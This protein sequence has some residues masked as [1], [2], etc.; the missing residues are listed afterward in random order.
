MTM[1]DLSQT[2]VPKSDQL[3]ADD[4]IA[5]PKTITITR[6]SAAA[7][8]ADQPV[9]ISYEGDDGKPYKP[10]K[11]M[12][13]VLVHLWGRDGAA[14][15]G[16]RMT[17]YRD[18]AVRFGG[19]EVGGIRISHMSHIDG[20]KT[21]ALTATRGSRK[22]YSVQPLEAAPDKHARM[23]EAFKGYGVEAAQILAKLGRA[24]LADITDADLATLRGYLGD[25]KQKTTTAANLF[26]QT[27]SPS[28][29]E[30][31]GADVRAADGAQEAKGQASPADTS[32]TGDDTNPSQ[33]EDAVASALLDCNTLRDV[34][35][36]EQ[37]FAQD[38]ANVSAEEQARIERQFADVREAMSTP[39]DDD[40][41]GDR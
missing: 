21:L 31:A 25:L 12:R 24:T 32:S 3:N 37:M 17:L 34:E 41:P 5:G 28:G 33:L 13:R 9:A 4:L 27:T 8:S 23:L 1:A 26:P 36:V 6:V 38:I 14:Y 19:I 22:P 40:F 39:V 30:S 29:G 16:R 20:P 35:S 7:S 15:A 2:I 10:C 11:S 18:P